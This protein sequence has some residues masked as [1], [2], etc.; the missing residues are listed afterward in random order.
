MLMLALLQDSVTKKKKCKHGLAMPALLNHTT[1]T[2]LVKSTFV[3]ISSLAKAVAKYALFGD[4][5][6]D[7]VQKWRILFNDCQ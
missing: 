7:K 4:I 3:T 5:W 6:N 1:G 2:Q